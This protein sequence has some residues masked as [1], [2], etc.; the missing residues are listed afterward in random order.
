MGTRCGDIDPAIIF[1]L[2]RTLGLSNDSIEALLNKQS[3]CKGICGENDMRS[4]HQMAD[5][6]DSNAQ[7]ALAMYAYRLTKYIG[8]YMAVLGRVDALVFTGGIGENDA[9]LRQHCL[10]SL[11][12]FGITLDPTQNNNPTR[13]IAAI[14]ADETKVKLLV[15]TTNEELAIAQQTVGCLGLVQANYSSTFA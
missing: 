7:L 1:Y 3:G 9:W 14:H 6:G 15:I 13:P 10:Q 2:S 4:V 11:T 8:S 5:D 12:A